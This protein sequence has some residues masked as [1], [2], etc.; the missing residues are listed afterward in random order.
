MILKFQLVKVGSSLSAAPNKEIY[1]KMDNLDAIA[2][3]LRID[4][5]HQL[6][7]IEDEDE[8]EV[9]DKRLGHFH[10]SDPF[11]PVMYRPELE[12]GRK[13]IKIVSDTTNVSS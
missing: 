3:V 13:R 6:D 1:S 9:E 2:A 12:I 4:R 7:D 10:S 5:Q 8:D 11:A